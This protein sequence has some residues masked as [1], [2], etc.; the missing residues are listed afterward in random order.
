M[1]KVLLLLALMVS[2]QAKATFQVVLNF[3]NKSEAFQWY[4]WYLDGGGEQ[5]SGY[6]ANDWFEA[7]DRFS[8]DLQYEPKDYNERP[9][10]SLERFSL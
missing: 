2:M 1:K 10:C 8:L 7:K 6:M 4:V 5:S 9:E 3:E